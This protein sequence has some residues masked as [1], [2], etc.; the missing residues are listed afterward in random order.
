MASNQFEPIPVAFA[1]HTTGQRT[2]S[3]SRLPALLASKTAS[4][5]LSTD[6]DLSSCGPR[7]GRTGRAGN[8]R[9]RIH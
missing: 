4:G 1:L 2:S 6:A 7:T 8:R 9:F 3:S 5:G